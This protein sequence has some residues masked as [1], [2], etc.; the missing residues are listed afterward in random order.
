MTGFP[1]AHDGVSPLHL[2]T[3]RSFSIS[4][5]TFTRPIKDN[6]AELRKNT[7]CRGMKMI[8]DLGLGLEL[9]GIKKVGEPLGCVWHASVASV[10]RYV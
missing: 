5:W 1:R 6:S 9:G 3:V 10:E 8:M 2:E 4:T 7:Q